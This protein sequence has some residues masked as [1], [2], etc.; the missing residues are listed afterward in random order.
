VSASLAAKAERLRALH[1]PGT[2]VVLPNAWDV[3]S[4]KRFAG[5]GFAAIATTSAG[6]ANA[7]GHPDGQVIPADEMLDAVARIA[8]AVDVP[9]SADLEAGYGL[10]DDELARRVIAAGCVGLNL[11]D[12]DHAQ[13]KGNL[14]AAELQAERIAKFASAARAAGVPLVV[15]A[16]VD[17]YLSRLAAAERVPEAIRRGR[18]YLDAGADCIYPILG[19]DEREIAEI[20]RGTR[21]AVNVMA[22]PVAPPLAR[23]A[24]IGVARVTFGSLLMKRALDESERALRDY[25]SSTSSSGGSALRSP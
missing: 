16:R 8:A 24:E 21:G 1:R 10:A 25:V 19:H 9:V 22:L 14:V 3:A 2:P 4:A 13:G 17:V 18:L 12:S 6:I 23:L 15:N 11:E 7:L 5:A 20:V